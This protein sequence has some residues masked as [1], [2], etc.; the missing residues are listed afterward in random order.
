MQTKLTLRTTRG[1][2]YEGTWTWS[3]ATGVAGN[4]PTGGGI[5]AAYRDFT[6]RHADYTVANFH[7]VHDFRGYGTFELPFGPGKFIGGNSSGILARVI[8]GWQFG[9]IFSMGTGSALNFEAINTI[10]RTGTPDIVG[11]FNR[12]GKVTWG[13]QFG[14]YFGGQYTRVP[15]PACANVVAGTSNLRNFCTNSAI[16]DANGNIVLQ[17]AA[18][19]TLGT[20]G[21]RPIDGPGSWDAD[22]NLQ[23]RIRI[24]ESRS[25][26]IRIDANNIFNHPTPGNPNLDINDGT[27]GEISTKTGSRTLSGQVRL[28]F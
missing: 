9:T 10:N 1:M 13:S 17:N 15:D 11:E 8:E 18:P 3:R 22:A 2:T 7:R 24:D 20:L 12:D 14:N 16:A 6:N 28:Q 23:K 21:L 27:F 4:T 26:T 19:G 5:T 25:V